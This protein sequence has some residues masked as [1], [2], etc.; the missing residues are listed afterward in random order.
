MITERCSQSGDWPE[1]QVSAWKHNTHHQGGIS[2]IAEI[3]QRAKGR[4]HTQERL[5]ALSSPS[6]F[7]TPAELLGSPEVLQVVPEYRGCRPG[8][9]F[10][11]LQ[12]GSNRTCPHLT[13]CVYSEHLHL[14]PRL[15][16]ALQGLLRGCRKSRENSWVKPA[17]VSP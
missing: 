13:F 4:S 6:V 17:S 3:R 2:L 12:L 15:W 11:S 9:V 5:R 16:E 10:V 14:L 7:L 8:R 1:V